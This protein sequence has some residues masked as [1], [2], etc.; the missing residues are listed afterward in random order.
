MNLLT[1]YDLE[2]KGQDRAAARV[3]MMMFEERVRIG[4]FQQINEVLGTID[5]S[6][7]SSRSLIALVRSTAI[8]K[9]QLPN[10]QQTYERSW[11]TVLHRGKDPQKLFVGLQNLSF[12]QK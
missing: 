5:I 8:F 4:D 11:M 9:G 1:V 6:R 10:W 7:L 2:T 12:L 3:L